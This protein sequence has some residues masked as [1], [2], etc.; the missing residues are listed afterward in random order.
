M[1]KKELMKEAKK[2]GSVEEFEKY[3]LSGHSFEDVQDRW[4]TI[5]K[6]PEYIGSK[7]GI[8]KGQAQGK[9]L[10]RMPTKQEVTGFYNQAITLLM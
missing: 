2:C 3:L 5:T 4:R 1:I 7:I 8:N 10:A 6:E 9:S